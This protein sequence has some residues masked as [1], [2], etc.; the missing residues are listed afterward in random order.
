MAGG[1]A[2]DGAVSEQIEALRHAAG[3][4]AVD[5]IKPKHD[6]T[7][8]RIVQGWPRD[9]AP[10]RAIALG[11]KAESSF[12]EIIATYLSDDRPNA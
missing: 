12:D 7:V 1:W 10:D 9:F 6:E 5:L 8:M 2:K 11:F 4:S 3:Q